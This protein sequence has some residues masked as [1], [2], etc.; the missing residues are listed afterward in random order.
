SFRCISDE[1][2]VG[3]ARVGVPSFYA[4]Q[5]SRLPCVSTTFRDVTLACG[6]FV[7]S[8][9]RVKHSFRQSL[10]TAATQSV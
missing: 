5:A 1:L 7:L 4:N 3:R 8:A 10:R 6:R 9:F 2:N